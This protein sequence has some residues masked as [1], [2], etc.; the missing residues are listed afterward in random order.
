LFGLEIEIL[1]IARDNKVAIFF[2]NLIKLY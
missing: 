2:E 1:K